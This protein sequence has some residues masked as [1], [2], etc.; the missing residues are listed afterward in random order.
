MTHSK[1]RRGCPLNRQANTDIKFSI[2]VLTKR[3]VIAKSMDDALNLDCN[4]WQHLRIVCAAHAYESH[5]LYVRNAFL[6]TN[7]VEL[8]FQLS[9]PSTARDHSG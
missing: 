1:N 6:A 5:V 3:P 4:H 9:L 8:S 7:T 2:V